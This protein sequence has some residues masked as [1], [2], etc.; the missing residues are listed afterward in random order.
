MLN[1]LNIPSQILKED[2]KQF[3]IYAA[4]SEKYPGKFLRMRFVDEKVNRNKEAR[5]S[6]FKVSEEQQKK[7]LSL[8]RSC[9]S[10]G[11]LHSVA[12]NVKQQSGQFILTV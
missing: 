9:G 7:M 5:N 1:N 10:R 11:A 8:N 2:S 6:Y 12:Y 4:E 3:R